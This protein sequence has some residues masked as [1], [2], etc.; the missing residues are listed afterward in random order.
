MSLNDIFLKQNCI[1]KST[2]VHDYAEKYEGFFWS[3]KDKPIKLLEIGVAKGD[4]LRSWYEYFPQAQIYGLDIQPCDQYSNDRIKIFQGSQIDKNVL[5][6]IASN[7]PFDI[8]IDDGS[9]VVEH[10]IETFEFLFPHVKNDGLYVFEDLH[11]TYDMNRRVDRNHPHIW[12]YFKKIMEDIHFNGR[13]K[14]Q[15]FYGNKKI[16]G[17]Q[18]LPLSFNEQ[19]IHAIHLYNSILFIEKNSCL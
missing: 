8:I 5:T 19:H 7:G 1:G 16:Q 15:N 18:V 9:H 4:S 13:S 14:N 11:C 17:P 2:Q 10:W 6:E 3:Y 12:E